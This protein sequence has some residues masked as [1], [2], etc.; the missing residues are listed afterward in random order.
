MEKFR[1]LTRNLI[2]G[3]KFLIIDEREEVKSEMFE[4]ENEDFL[5]DEELSDLE[6]LREHDS[7]K[8]HSKK[9]NEILWESSDDEFFNNNSDSDHSIS[10]CSDNFF[11]N[12]PS[13]ASAKKKIQTDANIGK[14]KAFCDFPKGI[15]KKNKEKIILEPP[16]AEDVEVSPLPTKK[17]NFN[18]TKNS[19]NGSFLFNF[20]STI[21]TP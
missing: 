21:S 9:P 6:I 20:K 2:L 17:V 5:E 7:N 13:I 15:L 10:L 4:K 14:T 18:L 1:L 12:S 3:K 16:L 11:V 8:N 19:L